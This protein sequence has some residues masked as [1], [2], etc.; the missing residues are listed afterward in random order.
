V[1]VRQAVSIG[2]LTVVDAGAALSTFMRDDAPVRE[3]FRMHTGAL[4]GHLAS[5]SDQPIR[6]YGEIVEILAE[7]GEFHAASELEGFWTELAYDYR[8][9]LLCGYSS[10][11]FGPERSAPAL[12]AICRAHSKVQTLATDPL[13]TWLTESVLRSSSPAV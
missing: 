5:T 2:A 11:H 10:A 6:V 7:R 3:L 12:E 13:G 8:M 9:I 1:D 4:V